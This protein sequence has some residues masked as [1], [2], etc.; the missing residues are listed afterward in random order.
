MAI[1]LPHNEEA[2]RALIARL[3]VEPKQVAV[4]FGKV[5]PS[6]L[7]IPDY[8]DALDAILKLHHAGTTIDIVTINSMVGRELDIPLDFLTL[9]HQG[10]LNDYVELIHAEAEARRVIAVGERIK[11]IG[12]GRGKNPLAEV[13]DE[14]R[15]L[16]QGSQLGNLYSPSATV[17]GYVGTL[18]ARRAGM[19]NGLTYGFAKLD[20]VL[21]P[22]SAGDMIVLAAR[23][24]VGKTAFAEW[25]SDHWSS[26]TNY[27]VLFA[28]LE[29]SK[30]Q[31]MD[32]IVSRRT[33]IPA[34]KI[35]RGT[36]S[37]EEWD[38]VRESLEEL[39]TRN[40]WFE[41]N[42]WSTT[43]TLRATAAHLSLE[44]GGL[45]AIVV[46]YLQI[47]KDPGDQEVQRVTRIS[48]NLKAMAREYKCPILVL[49][50][51]NRAVEMRD[52]K[53]P[54]L[55]DLRES[56]SIEQ[57]SDIVMGLTRRPGTNDL[58]VEIL[59]NRQGPLEMVPL[60]FNPDLVSFSERKAL[61]F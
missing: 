40:V 17:D 1:S 11:A 6:D 29:M 16:S 53:H 23:P 49:S 56:G 25:I 59:K 60:W 31:I 26:E 55:H 22:A 35:I 32:R 13:Q 7:Y 24:S 47:L 2:E 58:D 38:Q 51:L 30:D 5:A 45:G 21:Q 19:A 4:I 41:D 43:N 33:D 3:L 28:S 50:Q 14:I 10:D 61:P 52:N 46:D 18:A 20:E 37:D 27:P 57:D 34:Q 8:R 39:R 48:R 15:G 44:A 36:L 54:K 9:A 12:F 42:P